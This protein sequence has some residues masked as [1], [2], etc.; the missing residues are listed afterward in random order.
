[1]P[2]MYG[3]V[4]TDS[5]NASARPGSYRES[6][7]KWFPNGRVSLTALSSKMAKSRKITDPEHTWFVK[8]FPLQAG[9]ITIPGAA[10]LGL[11]TDSLLTAA[12]Q[13]PTT[14]P[15][16]VAAIGTSLHLGITPAVA[17]EIR[18]G[19]TI[20]LTDDSHPQ[21]TGV[22]LVTSVDAGFSAT[23]GRVSCTCIEADDNGAAYGANFAAGRRYWGNCDRLKINGN[24]HSEGA[25][26]PDAVQYD[27]TTHT[28][29]TQI[30][31]TALD[32]TR[33]AERT[34]IR[35]GTDAY[36]LLKGDTLEMHGWEIEKAAHTGQIWN[37]RVN[38][39][40]IRTMQGLI[41]WITANTGL[42][43]GPSHIYDFVHDASVPAGT[44][45]EAGGEDWLNNALAEIYSNGDS[46]RF[47]FDGLGASLGLTHLAEVF[48]NIN[49][50][51]SDKLYGLDITEWRT[52]GVNLGFKTHP[53]YGMNTADPLYNAMVIFNPANVGMCYIDDTMFRKA[54]NTDS[55]TDGRQEEYL[56]E[57]TF[58]WGIP[59]ECAILY[60]VGVDKP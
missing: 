44:T 37:S 17:A 20:Q 11:F 3:F 39:R 10:N 33:T 6:L 29:Y 13:V 48:G 25:D 51:P 45:W 16:A 19:H 7:L 36:K 56:T 58:E 50:T 1:M 43:D 41:P 12:Y 8:D 38:G 59:A 26:R 23:A 9:S 30:F 52:S 21:N 53:M 4:N 60:N 14:D 46:S 24:A 49:L 5:W 54:E 32:L 15:V 2:T 27:A 34:K 47:C 40:P 28:N 31:R 18:A 42:T 55:G 57:C 35:Y 22:L